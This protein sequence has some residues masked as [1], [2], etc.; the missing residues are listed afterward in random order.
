MKLNYS[1]G[2]IAQ[3]ITQ[4]SS[5]DNT[6]IHAISF[7]TRRIINGENNLFF[8]LDG[9]FRNG[10]DFIEEAYKK[11]VRHF[12]VKQKGSVQH[13]ANAYELVVQDPLSAL[14]ILAKHHRK[15]FKGEVIAITGSYGKTTV[16]EWLATL[17]NG[18]K[19]VSRSPKSYNSRLG[20]ALSLLEITKQT[21]I[22]I[23][24]VGI[25]EKGT[26]EHKR[27]II[28]PTQGIFTTFGNAHSELFASKEEHF[29]EKLSLFE[30][31]N[32]IYP[33]QLLSKWSNYLKGEKVSPNDSFFDNFALKN[34][35]ISK[36]NL[37]LA[38]RMA[39]KLGLHDNL[40]KQRIKFLSPL[41]QRM[42]IFDGRNGNT[43]INDT[44]N[45]DAESLEYSLSYQLA[46]AR[47][48][49]RVVLLGTKKE[50][51]YNLILK[52]FQP[53]AI[54]Y[55]D[56]PEDFSHSFSN[57]SILITGERNSKMEIIAQKMK[58]IN[59]QTYL[60]FNLKSIRHNIQHFKSKLK[61]QTKLLCMVKASSYGSDAKNIGVFLEKMG[62]DYL[63]VAYTNEGV[64]L[65]KK[66]I[67]T[68]ILVMNCEALSFDDCV[69]YELEPAIYSLQ[70]LDS[71][72]KTLILHSK[73]N[74]PIHLKI[75]TGMN[76]LG[77]LESE[78]QELIA[79]L[80]TQPEVMVKSMYSHLAESD[81]I[82]SQF[83]Q[84]QIEKF[85]RISTAISKKLPYP[86]LRHILNS[87][88]IKNYTFAQF[89][90]VRLGIGM[91]GVNGEKELR[92]AIAWYSSISQIKTIS[93]GESVGY[94]RS[95][96]AN[97][98]MR[99]AIIPVG[100]ADG[101]SRSLSNGNF[102]V[103]IRNF[104]C[105]LVGTIC[106]DM[107]MVDVSNCPVKE[108]D[109]VEIIGENQHIL[110]LAKR[111]GTISYEIMTRFSTRLHRKYID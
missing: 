107:I 65:R 40:I 14:E 36:Q 102:G 96:I 35:E 93:K 7:D 67:Q 105:P 23:I 110:N 94:N 31:N 63:G 86:I 104:F 24:E 45:L 5:N 12:V 41:A 28:Q 85:D 42:E 34:D 53:D 87:E 64:E 73:Y 108:G 95:F 92:P 81:V 9:S 99:I 100:Y 79:Y 77:F 38:I 10:Q 47:G 16:K 58:Q 66:G 6:V 55:I 89:D 103:Y 50:D 57:S 97:K 98:T 61:P 26:I 80:Q 17:L 43:I 109:K 33:E 18:Q 71:F 101:L 88:G 51:E 90:M 22:A 30:E 52:K 2:E 84:Q 37:S 48:K 111:T 46:N 29:L 75:E 20:V 72:V 13:L 74:Y 11:G 56:I 4:Q 44:Y 19:M 21:E 82:N 25:G 39:Q 106:M 15:L 68:P 78:I 69:K 49:K 76:R 54:H 3:I 62:V 59:H 60:E 27:E 8:A 83:T 32:F 1:F 70:Q 91:Y